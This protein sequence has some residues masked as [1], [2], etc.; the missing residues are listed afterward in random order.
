MRW[1]TLRCILEGFRPRRF[2]NLRRRQLP[3][4]IRLDDEHTLVKLI[5]LLLQQLNVGGGNVVIRSFR[6]GRVHDGDLRDESFLHHA[7]DD[8]I[9]KSQ[10]SF[11]VIVNSL[12]TKW[13]KI[14]KRRASE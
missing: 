8:P 6:S 7:V 10:I 1:C 3:G 2:L 11:L 5:F 12:I 9:E 4:S 13:V 14:V